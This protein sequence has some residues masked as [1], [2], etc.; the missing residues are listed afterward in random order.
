MCW[1]RGLAYTIGSINPTTILSLTQRLWNL[2]LNQRLPHSSAS[3]AHSFVWLTACL[4]S[5]NS[6]WFGLLDE[7]SGL[8]KLT[9]ALGCRLCLKRLCCLFWA[10]LLMHP[11]ASMQYLGDKN[12]LRIDYNNWG[13][14]IICWYSLSKPD[15]KW[16]EN[17][18]WHLLNWDVSSV[19]WISRLYPLEFWF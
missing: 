10:V 19:T 16:K 13:V 6:S 5:E 12:K 8:L 15:M 17:R 14:G 9:V 11:G 18:Y 1:A 3:R 7:L 2:L 4:L